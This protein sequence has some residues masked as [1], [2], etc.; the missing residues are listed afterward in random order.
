M[1]HVGGSQ[2][3]CNELCSASVGRLWRVLSAGCQLK[4]VTFVHRIAHRIARRIAPI[5]RCISPTA[6]PIASSIAHHFVHRVAHRVAHRIA[7]ASAC[8]R[9]DKVV[10]P[11]ERRPQSEAASGGVQ[12]A[13]HVSP[14][15]YAGPPSRAHHGRE[16]RCHGAK[17]AAIVPV[18]LSPRE[19]ATHCE[20]GL[21][22][23]SLHRQL[24]PLRME[25][26]QC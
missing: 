17:A 26:K 20:I 12:E 1:W 18:S 19:H 16:R 7:I 5:A 14:V 2:R 3:T 10:T 6:S 24:Q 8:H 23:T 11:C 25:H 4:M 9:S 22:V 15:R 13:P 21:I